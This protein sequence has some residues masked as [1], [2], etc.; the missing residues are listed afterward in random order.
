L[1]VNYYNG[2]FPACAAAAFA[3]FNFSAALKLFMPFSA[4][5]WAAFAVLNVTGLPVTSSVSSLLYFSTILA[6]L[7]LYASLDGV[8]L[9]SKTPP[10]P[11]NFKLS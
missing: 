1:F 3:L 4:Y 11:F 10:N 9:S 8:L 7:A 2:T 6:A 5:L